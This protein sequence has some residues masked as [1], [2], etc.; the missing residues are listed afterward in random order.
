MINWSTSILEH[1][2]VDVSQCFHHVETWI[3]QSEN[4]CCSGLLASKLVYLLLALPLHMVAIL[5]VLLAIFVIC[6]CLHWFVRL[7]VHL[8]NEMSACRYWNKPKALRLVSVM[9]RRREQEGEGRVESDPTVF[10]EWGSWWSRCF[11][12][13]QTED[14]AVC[15]SAQVS[16]TQSFQ[17]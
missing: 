10:K 11:V 6:S 17:G 5:K 15:C 8:R 2:H 4:N 16:D 12:L 7:H 3:G 9:A 1:K 14:E 13:W